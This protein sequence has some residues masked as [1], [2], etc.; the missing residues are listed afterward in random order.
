MKL[1]KLKYF[2]E[3]DFIMVDKNGKNGVICERF[4]MR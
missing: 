4:L 2:H 3:R 1:I